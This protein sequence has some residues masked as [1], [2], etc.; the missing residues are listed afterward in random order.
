MLD[1]QINDDI[2]RDNVTAPAGGDLKAQHVLEQMLDQMPINVMF[3][4]PENFTITYVNKTSIETLT[5]MAD[6]LPAPPDQLKG[7]SMDIF[8]KNPEHQRR[9][10]SDPSK[11]PW[12]SRITVGP[13]SLDLLVSAINDTDGKYLGAMLTWSVVTERV[14]LAKNFDAN[15]NSVVE[16]VLSASREVQQSAEGMAHTAGE[17]SEKSNAVAAASEQLTAAINEISGQVTR[18]AEISRTAVDEAMRSNE[19]VQGLAEAAER[20]GE[21]VVLIN[22]IANQTNLLALNATIEAARAGE[23]GKGFAVV[24]SE[25]KNLANQTAKATDEIASQVNEIQGATKESVSAIQKICSTIEEVS[26]ISTTI[27]S[28]VEEQSAATRE[29]SANIDGVT[30]ASAE[31][32]ETASQLLSSATGLSQEADRLQREVASFMEEID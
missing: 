30:Q 28:A 22:D 24:A 8:H 26:Q 15:I 13:E 11:L 31:A 3:V 4:E 29:V 21:V 18:S 19:M 20:I 5:P 32:G 17:T 14:A 25:V 12:K 10:I 2:P 16:T 6:L 27:S 9:I 23:A 1:Q 7:R